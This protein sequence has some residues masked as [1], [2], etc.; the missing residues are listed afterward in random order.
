MTREFKGIRPAIHHRAYIA[1]TAVVIGDVRIGAESSLWFNT[2]ARGDVNQIRIGCRSNIQDLCML[3]VSGRKSAYDASGALLIGD[4]VTVGHGVTLHGCT[5]EDNA[6]IGMNAVVLDGCVV[7]RG[8]MV[9]AG[10]LV[11]PGTSI[12]PDTLWLGSPA[13]FKRTLTPEDRHRMA[14]TTATYLQL[15]MDYRQS[16]LPPL[17]G[18]FS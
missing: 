13:R 7:G 1:D 16:N 6:F 11:T 5:I 10:S 2:I 9:A 8:A 3:H 4:D 15:A 17:E 18:D 14:E 12:P